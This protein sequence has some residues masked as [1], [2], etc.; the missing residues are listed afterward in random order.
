MT[1]KTVE[2]RNTFGQFPTGVT[3]ITANPQGH[4]PFGMTVNSFASLSLSPPLLLWSLQNDSECWGAFQ[5]SSHYTVNV[6]G[7]HQEDLSRLYAKKGD[8]TLLDEHYHIGQSGCVVLND[9]IASFEC[10]IEER[11][12]G[13][14]HTILIGRVLEFASQ[15]DAKPLVFFAGKYRRIIE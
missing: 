4:E 9:V 10:S 11:V 15:S 5:D 13:G 12:D 7:E 14:D 6:L 2:L 8:H 1:D 3:V